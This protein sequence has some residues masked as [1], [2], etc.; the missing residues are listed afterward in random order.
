[1]N[2]TTLSVRALRLPGLA[3]NKGE[4]TTKLFEGAQ[5]DGRLVTHL[6]RRSTI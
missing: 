5:P 3:A 6:A 4:G 2:E 1:V